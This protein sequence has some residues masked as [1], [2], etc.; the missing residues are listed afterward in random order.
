MDNKIIRSCVSCGS[1]NFKSIFTYTYDFMLKV[2]RV[3]ADYLKKMGWSAD[4]TSAI[5]KCNKC[6]CNYVRDVFPSCERSKK[7]PTPEQRDQYYTHKRFM[8]YDEENWVVRN[9][10]F[11][12]IQRQKRDIKFLDFGAGSGKCSNAARL[13]G[14]K[15][16]IAYDPYSGYGY[17][18]YNKL[19]FPGILFTRNKESL[20]GLAPFDAVVCTGVIEHTIDPKGELKTMYEVMSNGGYLYISD[21]LMD[22]DKEINA[23][24]KAKLIKKSDRISHYHPG[25]LNYLTPKQF[26]KMLRDTGFKITPMVFT[27]PVPIELGL[28]KN[29]LIRD[30]KF[31]IMKLLSILRLP[32]KRYLYVV[33]KQK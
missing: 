3:P 5:V 13:Y 28:I 7:T 6:G 32:Y 16:V 18:E 11:F 14:V 31:A 10:I 2:R 20:Y 17:D 22:L 4:V 9:L 21:P 24:I 29:Y 12:A 30:T 26:L 33:K 1:D 27:P 25:H 19:N 23:L 8:H 15:D